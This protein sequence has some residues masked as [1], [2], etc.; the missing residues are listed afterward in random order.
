MVGRPEIGL[1]IS[2]P[3]FDI[4]TSGHK[5][6]GGRKGGKVMVLVVWGLLRSSGGA[7]VVKTVV[8]TVVVR[9]VGA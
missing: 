6:S 2:M 7:V 4:K 5:V 3:D 9:C 8:R 1:D